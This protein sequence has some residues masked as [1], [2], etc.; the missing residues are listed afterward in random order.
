M[1]IVSYKC[2]KLPNLGWLR[3]NDEDENVARVFAK[4][5]QLAQLLSAT[6]EAKD[7][8]IPADIFYMDHFKVH[9]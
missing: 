5:V 2:L 7:L 9:P 1:E 8:W 4:L 3:A 6:S